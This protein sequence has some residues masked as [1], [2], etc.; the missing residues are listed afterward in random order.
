MLKAGVSNS[1]QDNL[2]ATGGPIVGTTRWKTSTS[3]KA[4]SVLD[5]TMQVT[6]PENISFHYQLAG[7]FRRIFAYFLDIVIS[8][9]AYAALCTVISIM[10]VLLAILA[11]YIGGTELLE[12]LKGILSGLTAIGWFIT[13]WFY[14]AYMETQYNGQT[15]GKR[16]TKMRVIT[17]HGH[18]IDGVQATLRNFFRLLDLMPMVSVGALFLIEPTDTE[19]DQVLYLPLIPTCLFGLIV[20]TI[21]RRYQRVGDLVASTVVVNEE[22]N[23]LPSLTSFADARVPQLAELIP[24]S[25]VVPATMAKTIAQYVDQRK[26]LLPQRASEIAS[27]LAVPLLDKFN[28][29]AD[30]DHDL[31]VCALYHKTFSSVQ[32]D[33]DQAAPLPGQSVRA[34]NERPHVAEEVNVPDSGSDQIVQTGKEF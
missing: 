4:S 10:F 29:P 25:F 24:T 17:I 1:K 7:P 2:E 23:R 14:G 20:M 11:T 8:L 26:F 6:T 28:I 31:F 12:A 34:E 13:Y 15:L 16:I 33:S 30:T 27:H 21:N 9:G 5:T 32:P 22:Q 19:M 18:A 3:K